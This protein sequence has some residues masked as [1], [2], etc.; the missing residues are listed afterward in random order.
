MPDWSARI[1]DNF[2]TTGG[3]L[4][5]REISDRVDVTLD[6]TRAVGRTEISTNA[7]SAGERP[8]PDLKSRLDS[9]R[10]QLTW[11]KSPRLGINAGVRYEAFTVE[12][13]ALEG[14]MPD[15]VPVLLSLGAEPYDYDVVLVGIGFTWQIGDADS[16]GAD[17]SSPDD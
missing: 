8:F 10:L 2:F 5:L 13:W 11:R 15:T 4:H 12:D 3:G 7:S 1:A 14:V 6:Y 16:S 9:L 17:S